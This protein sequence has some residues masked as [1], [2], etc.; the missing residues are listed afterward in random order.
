MRCPSHN[1]LISRYYLDLFDSG[2]RPAF[3][4]MITLFFVCIAILASAYPACAYPA[5][6]P[7]TG[8]CWTHD[9]SIIQRE[10]DG[11]Y[12]RFSTGTGVNTMTSPSLKGPWE[13]CGAAL[14]SGSNI[15]LDGSDKVH[16]WVC[17]LNPD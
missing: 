17:E 8:N 3:A 7:C 6:G 2:L 16:L 12:F 9:L 10:S 15:Q 14:P 1:G 13:D 4:I 11:M 5:P